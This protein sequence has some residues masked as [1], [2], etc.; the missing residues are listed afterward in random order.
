MADVVLSTSGMC[1]YAKESS[2]DEFIVATELGIIHR[3]R[4]ENPG[5]TF[6]AATEASVCPNMKLT[7]LED[8]LRSLEKMEH[9]IEVPADIRKGAL[10]A[11][12]NMVNIGA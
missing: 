2:A 7:M 5:K 10:K 9:K 12:E 6:Q 8:V 4:K 3:L 11:V 1:K